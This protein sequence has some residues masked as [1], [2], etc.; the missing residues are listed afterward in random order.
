M[1]GIAYF[2][3]LLTALVANAEEVTFPK[4]KEGEVLEDN[5]Y[6]SFAGTTK[7]AY[8]NIRVM[9][10]NCDG[11]SCLLFDIKKV[12]K[13]K[14][15][16]KTLQSEEVERIL[17]SRKS[18]RPM[19]YAKD[20]SAPKFKYSKIA[21]VDKKDG[22]WVLTTQL[23]VNGNNEDRTK[24]FSDVDE[25][26]FEQTIYWLYRLKYLEEKKNVEFSVFDLKEDEIEP[27]A[28]EYEREVV[29]GEGEDVVTFMEVTLDEKRCWYDSDGTLA[30]RITGDGFISDILTDEKTAKDFSAG[31]EGYEMPEYFKDGVL[32]VK[33]L[34]I[35]MKSQV[36]SVFIVPVAFKG[37][38][39]I[40]G[41]DAIWRSGFVAI[42]F[43][44]VP[45]GTKY[46]DA[47]EKVKEMDEEYELGSGK[48]RD[49]G[50]NKCMTG[51][52]T[53]GKGL[54]SESGEYHLF[55][56]DDRVVFVTAFGRS[57]TYENSKKELT[58]C[59]DSI[60]FF[61]PE[62]DK[63]KLLFTDK[64]TG[65]Q[66][67]LPNPGWNVTVAEGKGRDHFVIGHFWAE[68]VV[69]G[70]IQSPWQ[71]VTPE[72]ALERLLQKFEAKASGKTKIGKYDAV[73][74]DT[75]MPRG[76]RMMG[77]RMTFI[78]REKD[79]VTVSMAVWKDSWEKMKPDFDAVSKS[80][81]FAEEESDDK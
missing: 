55:V 58:E 24:T 22:S 66:L 6:Q 32:T 70:Q 12:I 2:I 35:K 28:C 44:G 33:E 34:G 1:I 7:V 27:E 48:V 54:E 80:L 59:I 42:S 10:T 68:A 19:Y 16:D 50:K 14:G 39:M 69:V 18:L 56:L 4:I 76:D 51:T 64:K 79:V 46:E 15:G 62:F 8:T 11:E 36:N 71:G 53:K 73:W 40:A 57:G 49:A 17:V 13:I 61:K 26:Y 25:V 23:N 74:L 9:R 52:F 38:Q 45:K 20:V 47:L 63:D 67:K 29:E 31:R 5:W 3:I 77:I 43:L 21:K 37:I 60:E 30:R 75:E 72:Q 65:L 78:I 81:S 41:F